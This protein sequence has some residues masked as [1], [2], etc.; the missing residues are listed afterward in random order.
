MKTLLH[1]PVQ[2]FYLD[3][4]DKTIHLLQSEVRRDKG[5]EHWFVLGGA[6]TF[7]LEGQPLV[8]SAGEHITAPSGALVAVQNNGSNTSKLICVTLPAKTSPIL[9]SDFAGAYD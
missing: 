6:V 3:L 4:R 2:G 1:S 9:A 8:A 7:L 5:Q